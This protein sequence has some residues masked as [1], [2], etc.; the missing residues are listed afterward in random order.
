MKYKGHKDIGFMDISFYWFSSL[1]R[2]LYPPR[3]TLA[4]LLPYSAALFDQYST[5]IFTL[6]LRCR[7]IFINISRTFFS[8]R[9]SKRCS[10]NKLPILYCMCKLHYTCN[11]NIISFGCAFLLTLNCFLYK[12]SKQRV[13]DSWY[14]TTTRVENPIDN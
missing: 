12:T 5:I 11:Y 10:F 13:R 9:G 8:L 4:R 14:K 6:T 3:G 2:M 7:I 1:P